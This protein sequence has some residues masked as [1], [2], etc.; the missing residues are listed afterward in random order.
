MIVSFLLVLAIGTALPFTYMYK[1]LLWL[2]IP[3]LVALV[4]SYIFLVVFS[5]LALKRIGQPMLFAISALFFPLI[6]IIIFAISRAPSPR[7]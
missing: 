7:T 1:G 3:F 2:K 6:P 5:A 4:C